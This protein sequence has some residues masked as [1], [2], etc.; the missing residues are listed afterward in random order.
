MECRLKLSCLLFQFPRT[1]EIYH[2]TACLLLIIQIAVFGKPC[3]F[4]N[5]NSPVQ[6]QSWQQGS[7]WPS[8]HTGN[9][10]SPH[11]SRK[12]RNTLIHGVLN[13][14]DPTTPISV[15]QQRT[16]SQSERRTVPTQSNFPKSSSSATSHP[17]LD[18]KVLWAQ[19]LK[20]STF[21]KNMLLF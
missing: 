14:S 20:T 10:P 2:F 5:A 1:V 16:A 4:G 19:V 12:S 7:W 18:S 6:Y 3:I 11:T 9:S 15:G 17:I 13:R 8:R 21:H